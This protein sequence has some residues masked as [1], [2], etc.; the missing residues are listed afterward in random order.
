MFEWDNLLAN[1]H[2]RIQI[3]GD[4]ASNLAVQGVIIGGFTVTGTSEYNNIFQTTLSSKLS[5][6]MAKYGFAAASVGKKAEELGMPS[7]GKLINAMRSVSLQTKWE[8]TDYWVN[9]QKP[10]FSVDTIFLAIRRK[11]DVREK[12]NSLLRAV[13]PKRL[14]GGKTYGPPLGYK[15]TK[16]SASG[17]VDVSV[18]QWFHARDQIIK[19]V[20]ASYSKEIVAP[21]NPLYVEVKVDFEPYRVPDADDIIG[22]FS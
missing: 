12:V 9:T 22:W 14:A 5:A 18:G 20:S 3:V 16:D 11:D 13:F 2:A 19:S 7:M 15:A 10:S 6:N 17:T 21:G 1:D 8:T 4:P